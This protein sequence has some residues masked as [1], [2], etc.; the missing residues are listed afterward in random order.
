MG[1]VF[2]Y[3]ATDPDVNDDVTW[4][5]S[6]TD[7]ANLEIDRNSGVVEFV[8]LPDFEDPQDSNR[9]NSYVVT[10]EASDSIL[11]AT[12]RLTVTVANEAEDGSVSFSSRQPQDGTPFTATLSDPDGRITRTTWTWE[13]SSD[14][15]NWTTVNGATTATTNSSYTPSSTNDSDHYLR[16][17]ATYRDHQSGTATR[18][19]QAV[20]AERVR[21]N[22]T[23]NHAPTFSPTETGQREI[24]ENSGMGSTSATRSRP[25]TMTA[26]IKTNWCIRCD[27]S[28][29]WSSTSNRIRGN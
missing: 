21:L 13:R 25:A 24:A 18:N 1:P 5:L 8:S 29:P 4:A 3:G 15:S 11:T 10:V 7:S 20:S 27:P 2:T 26:T 16:A 12:Q 23:T 14:K 9:N 6:G 17:T 19:A 28:T 22:P